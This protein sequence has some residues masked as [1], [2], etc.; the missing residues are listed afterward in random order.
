MTFFDVIYN[1]VNK[2][3]FQAISELE[4]LKI[5]EK[6]KLP[7]NFL[8]AVGHFEKRKNYLNLIEAL[9]RLHK[10]GQLET[11][12]IIGND[13]GELKA[14]KERIDALNMSNHV[15]IFNGLSD[16]EVR[17]FYR[18]CKLF[19]FPSLYEGFG[20]PIL[21]AMA[22][23]CSIV[24]SDIPVFREITQNKGA[25]FLHNDPNS[26]A[27]AIIDVLNSNSEQERLIEY[28][29]KRVEEFNFKK[30]AFYLAYIYKSLKN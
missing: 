20:I 26:I 10:L 6:F 18:S 14:V 12:V 23:N 29:K 17:Y 27:Q 8:L 30:M 19:I 28:G 16:L 1:G 3:Y 22:T 9:S 24:L 25:Y 7:E 15:Y 21:E 4:S 2:D 5:S 11:L 13:S